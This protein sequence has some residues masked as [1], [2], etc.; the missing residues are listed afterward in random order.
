[1]PNPTATTQTRPTLAAVLAQEQLL[2]QVTALLKQLEKLPPRQRM[3]PASAITMS[4]ANALFPLARKVLGRAA[5]DPVSEISIEDLTIT[6]AALLGALQGFEASHSG[7]DR[8]GV[9]V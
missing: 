3:G 1:M 7:P 9:L 8:Q 5:P 2:P 4:S 6:L